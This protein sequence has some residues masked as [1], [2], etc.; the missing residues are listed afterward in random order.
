MKKLI[1]IVTLMISLVGCSKSVGTF[2]ISN[3]KKGY[4]QIALGMSLDDVQKK[5]GKESIIFTDEDKESYLWTSYKKD[6]EVYMV[7][8]KNNKV[9]EKNI[10]IPEE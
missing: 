1:C 10:D 4:E 5:L 6:S 7:T 3:V 2:N 9:I 8:F